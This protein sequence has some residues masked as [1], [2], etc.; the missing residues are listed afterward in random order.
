[1][2]SHDML[3]LQYEYG[4]TASADYGNVTKQTIIVPGVAPPFVQ[5]YT[6]DELI[7]ITIAE[8]IKNSVQQWEQ[9]F[10]YNRFGNRKLDEAK[11]PFAVF[12]K[13]FGSF[14]LRVYS[15]N[16]VAGRKLST[17][18]TT[19]NNTKTEENQPASTRIDTDTTGRVI[20]R[21]DYHPFG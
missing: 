19:R 3:K 11:R 4:S 21:H 17:T 10:I 14:W 9:T 5:T 18:K 2:N 1:M 13:A 8:A 20:A 6:Y 15:C 7:R 16:F 12:D